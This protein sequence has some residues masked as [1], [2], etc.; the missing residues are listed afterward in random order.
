MLAELDALAA[1]WAQ[2][3]GSL[4]ANAPKPAPE[5]RVMPRV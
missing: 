3:P 2:K 5:L 4:E 1:G